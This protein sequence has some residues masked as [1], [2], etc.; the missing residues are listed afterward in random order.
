MIDIGDKLVLLREQEKKP[1]VRTESDAISFAFFHRKK[2]IS[3]KKIDFI[4]Q[5]AKSFQLPCIS[6][7]YKMQKLKLIYKNAILIHSKNFCKGA[8][9]QGGKLT[10]EEWCVAKTSNFHEKVRQEK[11]SYFRSDLSCLQ[12]EKPISSPFSKKHVFFFCFKT[13]R[14][15]AFC[16]ASFAALNGGYYWAC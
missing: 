4:F 12:T 11:K 3:Y 14:N 1:W 15:L 16:V 9:C 6:A 13:L 10:R 8:A 7:D 2:L 5:V